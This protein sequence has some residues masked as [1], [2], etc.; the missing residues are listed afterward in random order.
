MI[1]MI[2]HCEEGEARRS[3]LSTNRQRL[4]IEIEIL[5]FV[6]NDMII[7]SIS[8]RPKV[9]QCK[10]SGFRGESFFYSFRNFEYVAAPSNIH[11]IQIRRYI[12]W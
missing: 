9:R 10:G 12:T 1:E 2:R 8:L 6:Q 4:R 5:H 7:D 11:I 3:N